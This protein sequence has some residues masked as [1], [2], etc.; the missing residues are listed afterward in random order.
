MD[1]REITPEEADDHWTEHGDTPRSVTSDNEH[2]L[3]RPQSFDETLEKARNAQTPVHPRA[4]HFQGGL[5]ILNNE[6]LGV[7]EDVRIEIGGISILIGNGKPA[8]VVAS[9]WLELDPE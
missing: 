3:E 9:G 4:I 5:V 7:I 1:N 2:D 6:V 8:G